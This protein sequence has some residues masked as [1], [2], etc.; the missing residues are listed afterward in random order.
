[1]TEHLFGITEVQ[2]RAEVL[3]RAGDA[4]LNRYPDIQGCDIEEVAAA[5]LAATI[6][7]PADD[8]MRA[9]TYMNGWW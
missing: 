5:V 1:M 2:V 4:I 3:Q 6:E 7:A 9:Y 8:V